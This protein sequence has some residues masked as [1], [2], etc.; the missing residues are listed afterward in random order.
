MNETSTPTLAEE[1]A[2]LRAQVASLRAENT[3][4][5]RLLKLTP[6]QAAP[7]GPVQTGFFEAPPGPVHVGSPPEMKVAF[8]AALFAAR[9]DVYATRWENPRSGKAGRLPAGRGGWR[10][11]GPQADRAHLPLTA[12]VE[13]AHLAGQVH[14]RLSTL[15]DGD[16][17]WWLI[18][19]FDGS[20]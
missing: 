7:P 1:L 9:T 6:Q 13:P 16:R 3:R 18:T 20:R 19:E 15:L 5:L 11:G 8:F 17:C 2:G 12:V 10:K 4:L 14:P